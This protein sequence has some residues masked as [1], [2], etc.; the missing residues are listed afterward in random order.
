MQKQNQKTTED[1]HAQKTIQYDM[2]MRRNFN[3]NSTS[4]Q[5]RTQIENEKKNY[6]RKA[7]RSEGGV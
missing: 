2:R 4:I 6:Q 3:F 7:G 5:F 1:N